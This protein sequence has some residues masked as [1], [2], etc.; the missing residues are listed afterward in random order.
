MIGQIFGGG[1]GYAR[2]R[3]RAAAGRGSR[4]PP[5]SGTKSEFVPVFATWRRR[6]G[7]RGFKPAPPYGRKWLIFSFLFRSGRVQMKPRCLAQS[8]TAP[9]PLRQAVSAP[10]PG[11]NS[12]QRR[13][14]IISSA[15]PHPPSP[16]TV[17]SQLYLPKNERKKEKKRAAGAGC[18]HL[19]PWK[20]PVN[21]E[22]EARQRFILP[23]PVL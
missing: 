10:V 12:I 5:G 8:S 13:L 9:V 4:N 11:C 2:K 17:T 3:G 16:T 23:V 22:T 7:R 20:T 19:Q 18:C 14:H 15:G 1:R 21:T 6:D